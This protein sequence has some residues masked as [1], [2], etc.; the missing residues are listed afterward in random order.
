MKK[1]GLYGLL[2]L[3]MYNLFPLSASACSCVENRGVEEALELADA[4]FSGRVLDV[5]E[6]K[7]ADGSQAKAVHFSVDRAWK[8]VNETEIIIATGLGGGDCGI[9]FIV[10]EEYVVYANQSSWY[11]SIA[12]LEAIICSRTTSLAAAEEDLR[13]LGEGTQPEH[14]VE[15]MIGQSDPVKWWT[16]AIGGM[17]VLVVLGLLWRKNR[18]KQREE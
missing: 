9:D 15:L 18:R 10:G 5:Q 1:V 17:G 11:A 4:V 2:V 7:G 3:L 14:D 8:G 6:Q 13:E 16:G 12:P